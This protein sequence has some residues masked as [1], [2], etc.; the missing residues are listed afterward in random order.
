M[1]IYFYHINQFSGYPDSGIRT[2]TKLFKIF[3]AFVRYTLL[4][5]LTTST[6]IWPYLHKQSRGI[7]MNHRSMHF[8]NECVATFT[9]PLRRMIQHSY[10][11]CVY[12]HV[13][14][15]TDPTILIVF[16]KNLCNAG[17]FS[18]QKRIGGYKYTYKIWHYKQ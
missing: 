4:S 13:R 16:Y 15:H 14:R 7:Y 12:I 17:S 1:T 8:V 3:V 11:Q 10:G 6:Y 5:D 18:T 9:Q 2:S